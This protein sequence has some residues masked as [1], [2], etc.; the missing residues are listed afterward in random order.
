MKEQKLPVAKL[1]QSPIPILGMKRS[2]VKVFVN[3]CFLMV[4]TLKMWFDGGRER[5]L[6]LKFPWL[7]LSLIFTA[8][9]CLSKNSN[10]EHLKHV[11]P[12][13]II[14]LIFYMRIVLVASLLNT[15]EGLHDFTDIEFMAIDV[16]TVGKNSCCL[17]FHELKY[18][19]ILLIYT[20]VHVY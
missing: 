16:S 4:Y 17:S 5:V 2:L 6:H 15:L 12:G 18:I 11:V 14:V 10:F 13:N 19:K 3:N 20:F 8:M 9:P 1:L 7:L